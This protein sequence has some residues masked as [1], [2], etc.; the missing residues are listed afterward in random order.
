MAIVD[1]PSGCI[2]VHGELAR[3]HMSRSHVS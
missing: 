2:H 1:F 3:D